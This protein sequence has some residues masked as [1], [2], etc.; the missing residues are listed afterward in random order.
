MNPEFTKGTV[1]SACVVSTRSGA[2][3]QSPR[4]GMSLGVTQG[5]RLASSE[6]SDVHS[7]AYLAIGLER[8]EY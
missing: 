3:V 1:R 4:L 2:S 5:L 7:H 8:H 6:S